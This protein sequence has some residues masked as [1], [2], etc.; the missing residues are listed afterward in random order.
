MS[1][2]GLLLVCSVPCLTGDIISMRRLMFGNMCLILNS[3]L[4]CFYYLFPYLPFPSHT[5]PTI[6]KH[7]FP[8]LDHLMYFIS[9]H[10]PEDSPHEIITLVACPEH[11][12]RIDTNKLYRKWKPQDPLRSLSVRD[13]EDMY[14]SILIFHLFATIRSNFF[15]NF[16]GIYSSFQFFIFYCNSLCCLLS[17]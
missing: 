13:S 8:Q 4:F 15:T 7:Y 14:D 2:Y 17:L 12:S 9:P 5:L 1:C 6:V 3:C 16:S 11:F 10:V